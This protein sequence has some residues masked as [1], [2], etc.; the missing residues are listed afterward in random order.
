MA[1]WML[2]AAVAQELKGDDGAGAVEVHVKDAGGGVQGAKKAQQG[3]P[4][5]KAGAHRFL[6]SD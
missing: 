2:V 6:N 1:S 3:G 5:H 4:T